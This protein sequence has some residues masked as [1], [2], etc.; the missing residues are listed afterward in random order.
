MA[1][2]KT[3][4]EWKSWTLGVV[5]LL[6][7]GASAF[8]EHLPLPRNLVD[9]QSEAGQKYFLESKARAA[10]WPLA[11]EFVTQKNGAFC[12]VATLVMV[13]NSLQLPA[14]EVAHVGPYH[15][16]DQDNVFSAATE[17]VV[18]QADILKRG[19]TLDELRGLF[20]AFG[21][22][23]TATHASQTTLDE[24]RRTARDYLSRPRHFV[25][26]NYLRSTIGQLR[27]GH[28]SPLA[29]YDEDR[30]SFL[31]LDVA[32]FKYPPVWVA[33]TELFAAIG[34]IDA[35]N[36]GKTRGYLLVAPPSLDRATTT[37]SAA[38]PRP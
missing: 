21:V 3:L 28:I 11:S 26:V 25:V 27:D 35:G 22:E 36:G 33:A 38:E 23:A 14:P 6:A 37:S 34:T 18:A 8:A 17:A 31:I 9:L 24:F 20:A 4:I 29:A 12:G 16:F 32:R 1:E 10:Y 19:M 13:L 2:R 15:A 7:A 30:D 5:L